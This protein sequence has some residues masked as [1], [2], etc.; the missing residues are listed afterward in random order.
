MNLCYLQCLGYLPGTSMSILAKEVIEDIGIVDQFCMKS[1][2][3][4]FGGLMQ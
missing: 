1:S 3:R 4:R 2:S